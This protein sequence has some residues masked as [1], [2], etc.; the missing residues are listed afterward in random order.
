MNLQPSGAFFQLSAISFRT[1]RFLIGAF[2]FLIS[3]HGFLSV[4]P[5]LVLRRVFPLPSESFFDSSMGIS[6][7]GR[8]LSANQ[9]GLRMIVFP[10][11]SINK[12]LILVQI[13]DSRVRPGVPRL[14]GLPVRLWAAL[15]GFRHPSIFCILFRYLTK[16]HVYSGGVL[17]P[18]F[19]F[20]IQK[21]GAKPGYAPM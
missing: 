5:R 3:R 16:K 12:F 2:S 13:P 11:A 21:K 9:R 4:F 15:S 7:S 14:P 17:L 19:S 20:S 6:P 10:G 18:S 8:S 1:E